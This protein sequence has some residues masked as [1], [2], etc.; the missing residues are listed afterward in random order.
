MRVI[1]VL[2]A[3]GV[4]ENSINPTPILAQHTKHSVLQDK[5]ERESSPTI[6]D[7]NELETHTF[8]LNE[9]QDASNIT[10]CHFAY[11]LVRERMDENVL[12]KQSEIIPDSLLLRQ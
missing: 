1:D 7:S 5:G 6:M 2:W 10:K 3:D 11:V 8:K 12:G 4:F 9:K